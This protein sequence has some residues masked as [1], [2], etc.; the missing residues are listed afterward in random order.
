MCFA[1]LGGTSLDL[2]SV[3]QNKNKPK[4]YMMREVEEAAKEEVIGSPGIDHEELI[5]C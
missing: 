1:Q 2:L 4:Q 3:T 5:C